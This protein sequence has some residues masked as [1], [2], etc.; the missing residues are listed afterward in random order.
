MALKSQLI[1]HVGDVQLCNDLTLK[2]TLV[3]P[4]FKYN[5][6]LVS[7]LCRENK[8]MAIFHDEVSLIQDCA[9]RKIKGVGEHRDGLYYLVPQ[10]LLRSCNKAL[11]LLS[12][13]FLIFTLVLILLPKG[14]T[15]VFGTRDLDMLHCQN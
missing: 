12:T 14:W 9:T 5:L 2:G 6:L 8:C 15:L 7:K 10:H 3:V 4:A 1:T 13:H 11:N